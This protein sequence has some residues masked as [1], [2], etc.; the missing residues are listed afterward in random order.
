MG[1]KID[2][3]GERNINNFGSEMVIVGYRKAKDIDVYFPQY[4]WTAKNVQYDNF[5][6]GKIKCPYEPRVYN[7]GYIGEGK[8]KIKENGKL[9]KC[10]KIWNSMLNR[11]YSEKLHKRESTYINCKVCD[12]WHNLQNFGNWFCENYYEIEDERMVLDK[13]IL[14]KGNKT[15]SPENC[16]F[17]PERINSLFVKCDKSR[18]KYSIGVSYHKQNKKFSSKCSIY[19]YKENKKKSKHLGYYNTPQ[20]AFEVYK[21]FKENYIKQIADYYKEQIPINLYNTLY[22][23]EVEITD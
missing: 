2:R 18:G 13:D 21:Q 1:S 14:H 3:I 8:Y 10:Y 9:T 5:K 15:Y 22:D 16:I 7:I 4:N 19:D 23:Y 6:R 12:E 20:E 11:C 17:V